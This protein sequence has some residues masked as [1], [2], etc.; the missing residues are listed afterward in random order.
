MPRIPSAGKTQLIPHPTSRQSQLETAGDRLNVSSLPEEVVIQGIAAYQQMSLRSVLDQLTPKMRDF[1]RLRA[2]YPSDARARHHLGSPRHPNSKYPEA[3]CACG[4]HRD[5]WRDLRE[6]TVLGWKK[7]PAFVAA[8]ETML[9]EPL[10]F[11]QTT[12]RALA[13]AAVDKYQD[14]LMRD[15]VADETQRRAARDVLEATGLKTTVGVPGSG[16]GAEKDFTMR[17]ALERLRRGL[18]L[19]DSDRRMLLA[20]GHQLPE[21]ERPDEYTVRTLDGDDIVPRGGDNSEY[22]PD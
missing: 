14:L 18:E 19:S 9:G 13:P 8:Y 21:D 6:S 5:G 22:L 2:M 11:A 10:L 15:E 7:N 1:L 4:L 3:P 16:S 12:L 20:A 17:M